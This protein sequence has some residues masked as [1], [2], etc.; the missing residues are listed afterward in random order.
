MKYD[1][2]I[3]GSGPGGLTAGIYSSRAGFKTI[4]IEGIQPGGQLMTTTAV[5]NWPGD[6]SVM[7][8][9]LMERMRNH[10][11]A[12]GCELLQDPVKEITLTDHPF[13][14]ITDSK[15]EIEAKTVIIA[16]GANHKKL[17]CHGEKKYFNQG[18]STCAT[19]DGPF[20]KDK[21]VVIVGGGN[22]AVTEAEH[23]TRI[24]K[25]ITIVHILDKLTATDPIKNKVLDHP[26]VEFIYNSTVVEVKG[27]GNNVNAVVIENQNDK[28]KT[29]LPV[30]GVFIA[31]G[32]VPA[33][34]LF[35]GQLDTDEYGYL[36]LH[37]KSKTSIDGVFAAGD[38]ADYR[39]RQAI[40]SAGM[41]CMAA[42]DAQSFLG[43]LESGK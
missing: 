39:Y 1:I 4:I 38:V 29:N 32:F 37:D 23:L 25:K 27:D 10:A 3:I 36:K 35:K 26:N 19:C 2:A 31:I 14:L 6:V 42:L 12:Y 41:G 16:T 40:T 11:K 24:C 22:T 28:S 33:T 13:K 20:F 5:E 18:V 7:G 34:E 15:K 21:E 17:G 8:P 43:K 30:Q 9:D